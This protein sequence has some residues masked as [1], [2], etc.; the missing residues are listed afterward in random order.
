MLVPF[1]PGTGSVI[2]SSLEFSCSKLKSTSCCG[3]RLRLWRRNRGVVQVRVGDDGILSTW[4]NTASFVQESDERHRATCNG[5]GCPCFERNGK[6]LSFT[7]PRF[8]RESPIT[9]T[10]NNPFSPAVSRRQQNR[11]EDSN[12]S[13]SSGEEAMGSSSSLQRD[14]SRNR[15]ETQSS[16]RDANPSGQSSRSTVKSSSRIHSWRPG[17]FVPFVW[18]AL[19]SRFPM[20]KKIQEM[21]LRVPPRVRFVFI[22]LWFAWKIFLLVAFLVILSKNRQNTGSPSSSAVSSGLYNITGH[23][24]IGSN[25]N[26]TKVLYIVTSSLSEQNDESLEGGRD[27]FLDQLLPVMINAVESMADND[28]FGLDVDVFLV[29]SYPLAPEQE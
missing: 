25:A 27:R 12:P 11:V 8:H 2:D 19:R 18:Q 1:I 21:V 22:I 4:V 7:N 17:S 6:V 26:A 15:I 5:I 24:R 20:L 9:T 28:G 23:Q 3:I 14:D 16:A 13:V 29:C 10:M